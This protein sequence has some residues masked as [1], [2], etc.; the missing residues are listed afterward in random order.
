MPFKRPLPL[1]AE[2]MRLL[3]QVYESACEALH[4]EP[5]PPSEESAELGSVRRDMAAVLVDAALAG[6]R[7]PVAFKQ[8]ALTVARLRFPKP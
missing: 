8:R 7:D 4:L 6:E 2:A 1:D 3:D 5:R